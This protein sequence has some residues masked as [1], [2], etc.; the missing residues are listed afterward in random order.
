MPDISMCQRDD[1]QKRGTCYRYLATPTPDRQA[2]DE[3]KPETCEDH[4]EVGKRRART[5]EQADEENRKAAK[6]EA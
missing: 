5:L 6:R 3:Y 2:Y 4:W 1:C